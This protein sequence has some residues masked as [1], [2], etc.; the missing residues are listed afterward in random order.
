MGQ[1]LEEL[2]SS[3]AGTGL[4]MPKQQCPST[5]GIWETGKTTASGILT[6]GAGPSRGEDMSSTAGQAT[7]TVTVVGISSIAATPSKRRH[8]TFS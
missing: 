1:E 3:S 5:E 6:A 8:K 4:E 7:R 2:K